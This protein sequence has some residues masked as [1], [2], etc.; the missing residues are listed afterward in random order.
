M[1]FSGFSGPPFLELWNPNLS[2]SKY[3]EELKLPLSSKCH[4]SS[5]NVSFR[6]VF[7]YKVHFC[8]IHLAVLML[9]KNGLLI[10]RQ[11]GMTH[12]Y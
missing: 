10:Q 1:L 3:D 11:V 12:L 7:E 8:L 4:L 5:Q 2:L 9:D 6:P